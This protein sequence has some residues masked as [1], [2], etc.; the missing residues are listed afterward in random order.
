MKW[1]EFKEMV[2]LKIQEEGLDDIEIAWIDIGSGV[3][4]CVKVRF[5]DAERVPITMSIDD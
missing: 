3:N 1:S 5:V 2:D 4:Q